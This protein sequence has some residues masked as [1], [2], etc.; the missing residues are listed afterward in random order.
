MQVITAGPS[1]IRAHRRDVARSAVS[2][3]LLLA[4]GVLL[5]WLCFGTP[6]VSRFTPEGRPTAVATAIGVFAWGFAIVV[7]VGFLIVGV[8]RLVATFEAASALRPPPLA[9]SLARRLGPEYVVATDL[10]V[11]GGRRIH[12]L[13]LGPF[14][15]V[16][17]G[18]VPP[19][20]VSR[21][22]GNLWEIRDQRGRWVPV[23]SP[24]ERTSR[25]ME[26][27]RGWLAAHDRDFVVRL[28]AAIVTDDDRLERTPTCAVVAPRDLADWLAALPPQR[29]LTP[30]RREDLVE[31]LESVAPGH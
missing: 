6:L 13:V 3:V 1:I 20:A 9:R 7:P 19:R 10:L 4:V 2:A 17:L 23:E 30:V 12:E 16:V 26:R 24:Q 28:Y 21:R 29:G 8:A 14:G 18:S 25:D 11:P 15:M 5:A 22:A 31:L 27:V